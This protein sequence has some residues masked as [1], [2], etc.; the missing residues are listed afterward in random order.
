MRQL[1]AGAIA[2][3]DVGFCK[4]RAQPGQILRKHD[5]MGI[6]IDQE[7]LAIFPD[8]TQYLFGNYVTM[9]I[10]QMQPHQLRAFRDHHIIGL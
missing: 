8:R 9:H 1:H 2:K 6:G 5:H 7:H 3:G 4:Q 10:M